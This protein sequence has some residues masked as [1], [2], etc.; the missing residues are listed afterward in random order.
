MS[1]KKKHATVEDVLR[2]LPDATVMVLT[3]GFTVWII[4]GGWAMLPGVVFPDSAAMHGLSAFITA[5]VIAS[6]VCGLTIDSFY[7]APAAFEPGTEMP[8][9][10]KKCP[11]EPPKPKG[12]HHC[13][14][15]RRCVVKMDHHCLFLNNCIGDRNMRHFVK[16]VG[17]VFVACAYVFGLAVQALRITGVPLAEEVPRAAAAAMLLAFPVALAPAALPFFPLK[18]TAVVT[19]SLTLNLCGIVAAYARGVA[20]Y[21]PCLL[22]ALAV[23]FAAGYDWQQFAALSLG[24]LGV[25]GGTGVMCFTTSPSARLLAALAASAL[26]VAFLTAVLLESHLE[27]LYSGETLLQRLASSREPA[28]SHAGTGGVVPGWHN[29]KVA[30]NCAPDAPV[31]VWM[32]KLVF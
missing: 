9:L 1:K 13:S 5:E 24:T 29:V 31:S 32:A 14:R 25:V 21:F 10:C 20:L 3:A 18:G 22:A 17:W 6:F 11:N 7:R 26:L 8:P 23:W 2:L 19:L 16:Y 4:G 12:V 30:L 28:C 15:C 27:R